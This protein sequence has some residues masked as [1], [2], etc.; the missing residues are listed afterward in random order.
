MVASRGGERADFRLCALCFFTM[1][2]MDLGHRWGD[3]QIVAGVGFVV[4]VKT[5]LA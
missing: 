2:K 5:S 4:G 1:I 3:E